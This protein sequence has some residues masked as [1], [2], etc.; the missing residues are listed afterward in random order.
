MV[1]GTDN[2]NNA[3]ES[4]LLALVMLLRCHGIPAEAEQIRHRMGAAAIGVPEMLRYAKEVGLKAR[5][6]KTNWARLAETPLPVIAALRDGS[7]LV[8]GKRGEDKILVQ[9]TS[10][11][12]PVVMT[13]A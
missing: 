4:G 6:K 2:Q 12:R 1:M 11:P 3:H 13:R 8:L 10:S 9:Q 7:F 5:V